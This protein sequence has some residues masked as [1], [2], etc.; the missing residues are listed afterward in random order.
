M[1]VREDETCP[2]CGQDGPAKVYPPMD[3][4]VHWPQESAELSCA[5]IN[6]R[7]QTEC[8]NKGDDRCIK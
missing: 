2:V 8:I 3:G 4:C 7:Y 1:K 5:L 6:C